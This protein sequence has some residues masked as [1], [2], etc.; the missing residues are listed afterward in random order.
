LKFAS[1]FFG[2]IQLQRA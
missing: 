2:I 1:N